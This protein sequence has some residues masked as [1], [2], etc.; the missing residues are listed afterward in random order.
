[1]CL[2]DKKPP[3]GP[4]MW[5]RV[6]DPE[7]VQRERERRVCRMCQAFL[8]QRWCHSSS[9]LMCIHTYRVGNRHVAERKK[10]DKAHMLNNPGVLDFPFHEHPRQQNQAM[11][12]MW[13]INRLLVARSV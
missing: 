2:L 6:P 5:Y 4:I 7:R 13:Q 8:V 11:V 9:C 12:I 10:T 3:L 1:M